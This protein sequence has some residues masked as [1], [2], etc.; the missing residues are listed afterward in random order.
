MQPQRPLYRHSGH[1]LEP[2]HFQQADACGRTAV[3]EA[4]RPCFWGVGELDI[5]EAAL[6]EG[7]I[8][9][10]SACLRFRDGTE[11]VI[12]AEPEAGNAVLP[13]R[14]FDAAWTDRN[15]PLTVCVGLPA[16]RASGNVAGIAPIRGDAGELQPR[17]ERPPR[18]RRA[19][20]SA[21]H[22]R[23]SRLGRAAA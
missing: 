7:R 11:A 21:P 15:T 16:S 12:A 4:A 6:A 2:Q 8:T 23:P 19:P 14:R 13:E 10:R 1:Y 20:R 18:G 3:L 17:R 5:D 22:P 9:V